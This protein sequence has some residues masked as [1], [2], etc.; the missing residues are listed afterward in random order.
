M[1]IT[2]N[3]A[4]RCFFTVNLLTFLISMSLQS[5]GEIPTL[6]DKPPQGAQLCHRP[7]IFIVTKDTVAFSFVEVHHDLSGR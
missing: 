1:K 2:L 3:L 4:Q 5:W 6:Y 7:L